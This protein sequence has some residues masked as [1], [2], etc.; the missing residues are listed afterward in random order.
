MIIQSVAGLSLSGGPMPADVFYE[1]GTNKELT[2]RFG[3]NSHIQDY[4]I[5]L[6]TKSEYDIT[7]FIT[8]EPDYFK[9]MP[10]GSGADF[11][12]KLDFFEEQ[13]PPGRYDVLV[14]VKETETSSGAQIGALAQAAVRLRITAIY[15]T[16]YLNWGFSVEDANTGEDVNLKASITN[17]GEPYINDAVINYKIYDSNNDFIKE[18]TSDVMS[19]ASKESSS[20]ITSFSSEGM[21]PDDYLVRAKISYAGIEN[22]QERKFRLGTKTVNI[23]NITNKFFP[24]SINVVE[25][26]IESGWNDDIEEIKGSVEVL[27][28]KEKITEFKLQETSLKKWRKGIMRGYFETFGIPKG[29]YKAKVKL[30][31]G[32]SSNSRIFDI[33]ITDEGTAEVTEQNPDVLKEFVSVQ[34]MILFALVIILGM[35]IWYLIDRRRR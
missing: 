7:K 13:I 27:N 21:L 19:V 35:N 16:E 26:D 30:N 34:N 24:E 25:V 15:P 4:K 14:I 12:I 10:P 29:E 5:D 32:D 1:Y 9:Q 8:V 3:T 33:S 6:Y 20:T 17:W 18:V 23:N 28:D 11:K 22:V 31:Y 2:Y